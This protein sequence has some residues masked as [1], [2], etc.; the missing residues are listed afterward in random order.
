MSTISATKRDFLCRSPSSIND[1]EAET[2]CW[3]SS[4]F[5]SLL[6]FSNVDILDS[7]NGQSQT[8]SKSTSNE[9]KPYSP[10]NEYFG[11]AGIIK[12]FRSVSDKE[13]THPSNTTENDSNS[14]W[15]SNLSQQ[16]QSFRLEDNTT[17]S[18]LVQ[19]NPLLSKTLNVRNRLIQHNKSG[20]CCKA[21]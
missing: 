7:G 2:N 18:I 13:Q 19:Y 1:N 9:N 12:S 6:K 10:F 3:E 16:Y 8:D 15:K 14:T 11:L 17:V 20:S 21:E 5:P 4:S